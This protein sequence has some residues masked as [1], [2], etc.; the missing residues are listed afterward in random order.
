MYDVSSIKKITPIGIK[1]VVD[2]TVENN[3]TFV[4]S[5]GIVVHNCNSTQPALRNFM[6]EFSKNCGFILTCNFKN[7]IIEPLQSRCSVI[8]F[9]IPKNERADIAKQ[10]LKRACGIL[11]KE[12]VPSDKAVVAEVVKKYFPD[13]RRALNELQRYSA[14]GAIDTGILSNLNE[15]SFKTLVGFLQQKDFSSIRKWVGE[16][17]DIEPSVLFRMLYDT[18]SEYMDKSSVPQLVL[19]IAKYQ[20]QT[21]FVADHEINVMACLIEIMVDCK[22][23]DR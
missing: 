8:D 6:E 2:I 15:T 14:T 7:R 11:Q 17:S 9:K 3:H 1:N 20:Y 21:A 12:N 10:F 16:N 19:H 23:D 13:W 18:S 4:T 5:N 22:F